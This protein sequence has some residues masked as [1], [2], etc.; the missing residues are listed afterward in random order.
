VGF[1]KRSFLHDVASI[2]MFSCQV[3][4]FVELIKHEVFADF[5]LTLYVLKNTIKLVV[6]AMEKTVE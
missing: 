1:S 6:S 3:L 5:T 4:I 2:Q